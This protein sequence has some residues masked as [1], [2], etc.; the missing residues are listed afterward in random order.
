MERNE[1]DEQI[2]DEAHQAREEYQECLNERLNNV[3]AY[4]LPARGNKVYIFEIGNGFETKSRI[5]LVNKDNGKEE[6][7][8]CTFYNYGAPREEDIDKMEKS[9]MLDIQEMKRVNDLYSNGLKG[10]LAVQ[11]CR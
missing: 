11:G 7:G 9:L 10:R 5:S 2:K 1:I 3:T 6:E 8:I 4:A